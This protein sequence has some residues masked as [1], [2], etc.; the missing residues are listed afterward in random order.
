MERHI[1]YVKKG[2]TLQNE[3]T[4][5]IFQLARTNNERVEKVNIVV[6]EI[7]ENTEQTQIIA[8]KATKKLNELEQEIKRVGYIN[9]NA[10]LLLEN[11]QK[12]NEKI[13]NILQGIISF[14]NQTNLLALNAS[15]EAARAGEAGKGFA[16]VADEVK[17]LAESSTNSTKEIDEIISAI[18]N[19]TDN[20][21]NEMSEGKELIAKSK[22]KLH[23]FEEIFSTIVVHN[24][25]LKNQ[26]AHIR[27]TMK[28]VGNASEKTVDDTS[29]VFSVAS[30]NEETTAEL[31]KQIEKQKDSLETM[32]YRYQ[33][34]E[35]VIA[36]M[37]E[38]LK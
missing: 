25:K 14:S 20:V 28:E 27:E 6:E 38:L 3:S 19:E 16:V 7:T 32:T 37:N 26:T 36:Q 35:E 5:K 2:A 10:E 31:L 24:E 1:Q 4:S 29:L 30:K 15:I 9:E 13:G 17:K 21:V 33:E 34:M 8:D 22:D 23:E 11:L 18:K 12:Q